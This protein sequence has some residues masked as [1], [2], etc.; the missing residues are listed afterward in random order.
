ME[1]E[2]YRGIKRDYSGTRATLG[3]GAETR[4]VR[5]LKAISKRRALRAGIP[6]AQSIVVTEPRLSS[7]LAEPSIAYS[8]VERYGAGYRPTAMPNY[9]TTVTSALELARAINKSR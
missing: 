4:E 1:D 6:V 5:E 8:S 3:T 7:S 2:S 9:P